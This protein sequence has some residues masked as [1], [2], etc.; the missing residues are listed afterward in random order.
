[1]GVLSVSGWQDEGVSYRCFSFLIQANGT[2]NALAML[3]ELADSWDELGPRVW[4]FFQNGSQVNTLRV[5]FWF[6]ICGVAQPESLHLTQ[7]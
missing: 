3:K 1:M 4:E 7:S 5:R 2:F 6:W